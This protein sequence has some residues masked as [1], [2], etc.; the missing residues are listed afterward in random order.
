MANK[1]WCECVMYCT[2][3]T[4]KRPLNDLF[5][6]KWMYSLKVDKMRKCYFTKCL[7]TLLNV[8][9][10]FCHI[11]CNFSNCQFL[12]KMLNFIFI[13]YAWILS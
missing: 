2:F 3:Q 11:V 6:P 5:G 1:F 13:D 4:S 10:I 9:F 7:I 8:L 12:A